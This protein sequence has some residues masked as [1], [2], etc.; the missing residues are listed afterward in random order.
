MRRIRILVADDEPGIRKFVRANLVARDYEVLL[1]RDGAE[2]IDIVEKTLPDLIIL[3]I[4]MPNM[5]GVEVCRRIREW[6]QIPI[7]I[8]SARGEEGDKVACLELGADDY[9]TKPFG[10]DELLARVRA[11]Q[12]RVESHG[13]K[14]EPVYS[15]HDLMVDFARRWV[16]LKGRMV[17]LTATEY[18]LVSYL[19][20]NAGRILT[21]DQILEHVWGEDYLGEYHILHV[22]IARLREKLTDGARNPR[23]IVTRPGI[24]YMMVKSTSPQL[25]LCTGSPRSYASN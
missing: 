21:P 12:R 4:M 1:A 3:D 24:G 25:P 23:Y 9:I 10:V 13:E 20:C 2:A 15:C 14:S 22:N 5:D 8:L 18:K 6:S 11:V 7:I 16:T 19:A 17:N